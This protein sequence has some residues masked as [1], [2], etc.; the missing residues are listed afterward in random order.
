MNGEP[1]DPIPFLREHGVDIK[2]QVE[3][4]YGDLAAS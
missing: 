1:T 4:V 3:S 2:L